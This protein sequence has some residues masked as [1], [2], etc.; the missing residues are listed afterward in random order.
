MTHLSDEQLSAAW[1]DWEDT[2][3]AHA[4]N[5]RPWWQRWIMNLVELSAGARKNEWE[6]W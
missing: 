2:L 1:Q 5:N 3:L 6:G 4:W